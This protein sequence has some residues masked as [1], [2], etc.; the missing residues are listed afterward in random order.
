MSNQ[1]IQQLIDSM[2]P[3]GFRFVLGIGI[4]KDKIRVQ[5][6]SPFVNKYN[7]LLGDIN[8]IETII[9]ECAVEALK[10]MIK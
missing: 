10:T 2:I 5:I 6:Y 3:L 1:S 9:N 4:P 8:D 7:Y